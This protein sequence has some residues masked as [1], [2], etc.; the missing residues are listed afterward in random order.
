MD[1]HH[2]RSFIV[3]MYDDATGGFRFGPEAPSVGLLASCFG[4]MALHVVGAEPLNA[5]KTAAF[6]RSYQGDQG[7]FWDDADIVDT[8]QKRTSYR[9]E[10]Y[11]DFAL[12]ALEAL[13]YDLDV[14]GLYSD[15]QSAE[16][17]VAWL[18][19]L[20]WSYPWQASNRF[21]FLCNVLARRDGGV[22]LLRS[23]L[24]W[25]DGYQCNNGLWFGDRTTLLN[26]VAAAYHFAFFYPAVGRPIPR[27]SELAASVRRLQSP[28]GLFVAN[29]GGGSC[30][31]IDAVD[32]LVRHVHAGEDDEGRSAEAIQ[33]AY[34]SLRG[35][36]NLDGGFCWGRR[37]WHRLAQHRFAHRGKRLALPRAAAAKLRNQIRGRFGPPRTWAYNG[38]ERMRLPVESSDMFSTWFRLASIGLIETAQIDCGLIPWPHWQLRSM[39]GLGAGLK[40]KHLG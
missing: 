34:I 5:E 16:A 6:I 8:A 33:R 37:H 26:A 1:I 10:Q 4:T 27:L 24:R 19:R 28:D 35:L 20:D 22:P 9:A 38:A 39:P 17:V 2:A 11:T 15:V 21:M 40:M 30:E 32:L 7:Y 31:D 36:Q 18:E 23:A 25:L 14:R 29:G 13:G 3:D 12:L